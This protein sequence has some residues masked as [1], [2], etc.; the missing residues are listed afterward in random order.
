MKTYDAILSENTSLVSKERLIR[1]YNEAVQE[2]WYLF[3]K[4]EQ[5]REENEALWKSWEELMDQLYG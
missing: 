2:I 5:I 4:L 1:M 3:D